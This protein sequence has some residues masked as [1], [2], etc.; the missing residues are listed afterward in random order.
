MVKKEMN[1]TEAKK[2]CMSNYTNLATV[3]NSSENELISSLLST[4]SW[5]GLFRKTWNY[6]S[7]K[8]R[9]TFTNWYPT[10]PDNKKIKESCAAVYSAGKWWNYDCQ[11]KHYFICQ[12]V[13]VPNRKMLRLKFRTEADMNDPAVKQ[14]VLEQVLQ[15]S[16]CNEL[17]VHAMTGCTGFCV[18]W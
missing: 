1:W 8:S 2:Y 13:K 18:T 17:R 6:W 10:Q 15:T 3:K 11:A 9:V 7:D 16:L 14:Q 4:N 5:I 12:K